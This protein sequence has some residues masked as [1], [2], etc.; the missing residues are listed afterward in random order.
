MISFF[1]CHCG[2]D[3]GG[4]CVE[5]WHSGTRPRQHY[6]PVSLVVVVTYKDGLQEDFDRSQY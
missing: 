2:C 4:F 6:S 3:G 5:H 1:I